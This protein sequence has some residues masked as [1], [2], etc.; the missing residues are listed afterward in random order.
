[1]HAILQNLSVF[2]PHKFLNS[3]IQQS[4]YARIENWQSI[5]YYLSIG[6]PITQIDVHDL[7]NGLVV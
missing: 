4:H 6:I 5:C 3:T 7:L 1:M 2:K